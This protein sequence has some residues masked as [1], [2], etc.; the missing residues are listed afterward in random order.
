MLCWLV[1]LP[2]RLD[3]FLAADGRM[4]SRAR[5][6]N[7]IEHGLVSVNGEVVRKPAH[8]LQEGDQVSVES[9]S[10][11]ADDGKNIA[12]ADLNLAILYEDDS[13]MAVNKPAG[14]AVHPG[15]GMA[16]G[17][18]TLLNGVA[19][20]F[21]KR[22]I[23]FSPESVL[24]HRLD[25]DTTGCLLV[26]KTPAAHLFLQEQFGRRTVKKT[27]LALV[28]GIPEFPEA[29]VDA[30]I[31]RSTSDRTHM[32]VFHAARTREAQ[33]TYRILASCTGSHSAGS[34]PL[35]GSEGKNVA[36]LEC[37][38]H[39]GRT[40][41]VRVH[42]SAIGHPVLGDG[43]YTNPLS[44]RISQE[45]DIRSLCL[46]A[47][48]LAFTSPDDGDEHAVEA[49]LPQSFIRAMEAAGIQWNDE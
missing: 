49:P 45:C 34:G 23:R 4:P 12:P 17:E 48:K 29:T 47:W 14:I 6:Q 25:K 22:N 15:A 43:T 46:H 26:A 13:C 5:A 27:Y 8:R 35:A 28:A 31:G 36:L 18:T 40:H 11:G 42:L 38:L 7:A 19:H 41:Q 30:P 2:D 37:N 1:S 32:T 33:T 3:S 9:L 20:L 39:T 44:E 21:T 10:T 16:P 24:V